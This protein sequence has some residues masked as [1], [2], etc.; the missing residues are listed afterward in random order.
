MAG[1]CAG[2]VVTARKPIN[3]GSYG[4]YQVHLRRGEQPCDL[5]SKAHAVYKRA[6][7][8]DPRSYRR[9]KQ[10]QKA[11]DAALRELSHLHPDEYQALYTKHLGEIRGAA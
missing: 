7:R 1:D 2:S 10:A 6:Y 5:C 9:E 4:G 8:A 11:A 3:H